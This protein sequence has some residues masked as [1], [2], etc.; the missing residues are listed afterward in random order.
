[1]LYIVQDIVWSGRVQPYNRPGCIGVQLYRVG[2][3]D[4]GTYTCTVSNSLGTETFSAT[5]L[6]DCKC[7]MGLGRE[8]CIEKKATFPFSETFPYL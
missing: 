1:M 4:E 3:D 6:V 8:N 7:N 2:T 5:L